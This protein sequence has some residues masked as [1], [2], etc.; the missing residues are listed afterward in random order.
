[1]GSDGLAYVI[2][3]SGSTGVPKGVAVRHGGVSNLVSVFGPLMGV[4]PGVGVLQFASFSFDASVLD[5]AVTLAWGGALVVAGVGERAEPGLLRGL[6]ASAGV[7]SASVV[8]SLLGV[9]EPGDL[10]GVGSLVIGAEAVEPSVAAV[11]S[12]G[13]RLVN[14]YGPT[15]ATVIVAAG[16]VDPGEAAAGGVVPF[17]S[18]VANTRLFVLDRGLEPVPV[19]VAG[20]LYVAG[21][22]LARGYHGRAGLSAERFV[23]C[24]FGVAGERMYRTGDLVRWGADGRLVFVGR[25]DEQVKVRGFR[26]ELGEVQ[27]VVGA[28]AGVA[29]AAVVAREDM[30]GEVRL[31]AYVVGGQD[32]DREEL[33]QGVRRFTA[34]R[35]PEYMVPAA[36][37]VLDE[38]PLTVNGKLDRK[39]LPAPEYTTGSGRG[40]STVRE[41]ILC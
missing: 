15:E 25:A 11:W 27:A 3:T 26:I 19:G 39:A 6:V 34:S 35:L 2:Y 23:A 13:R 8:P 17:G 32:A 40:P 30:P 28:H 10:A 5:V 29:R 16:L 12:R 37:M 41:E 7:G 33:A 36:V 21:A 1:M 24:P 38:L 18:P 20:E 31:V 9:L 22:Q 14:T 4:G